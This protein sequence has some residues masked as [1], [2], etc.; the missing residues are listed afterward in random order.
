MVNSKLDHPNI[1][2]FIGISPFDFEKK[3]KFTIITELAANGSLE[4]V[5]E[6]E[7][8]GLSPSNWNDTKKLIIIYGIA[9]G[10]SY[11][12][13]HDIIHRDLKPD[14]IL[15]NEYLLPKISDFGLSKVTD[16]DVKGINYK[17]KIEIKGTP[18]FLAPETWSN[19][20]FT[21]A[22][23]VYAYGLIIYEIITGEIP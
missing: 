9:S 21:K 7:R 23:D 14:N 15:L 10:I 19:Y 22:S 18:V 13:E 3:P 1:L 8:H 12:H 20:E 11:L 6:L 16:E 5:L 2:K 4:N 17:S